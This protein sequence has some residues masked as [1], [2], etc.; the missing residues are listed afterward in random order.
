[1]AKF[2]LTTDD[3]ALRLRMEAWLRARTGWG[4]LRIESIEAIS[5]GL[6]NEI[7][8]VDV[9]PGDPGMG[10]R[11]R[12][13][14]RW[15]PL[16]GP[17]APY[18]MVGQFLLFEALGRTAVPVPKP[19][20][21]EADAS[22]IGRAFWLS[23]FVEGETM[24]RLLP[25][26]ASSARLAGFV[27]ALATIHAADWGF[28]GLADHCP[29]IRP[30]GIAG[31][32]EQAA[33]DFVHL[34]D[35]DRPLFEVVRQS[36]HSSAPTHF[37][38]A[39]THGDCSLSNYLFRG[40]RVAAVVDWDLRRITD[41]ILDLG[42]YCA[43]SDRFQMTLLPADRAARRMRV[44]EAY[45]ARTGRSLQTLPFW[46]MFCTFFNALTWVRPGWGARGDGFAAYRVRLKELLDGGGTALA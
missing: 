26:N 31:L 27:D 38:P 16:E 21:V 32:V 14:L 24:G 45:R 6:V 9:D 17:Y 19:L 11:A 8:R 30:E 15:D 20:W 40:D 1:M 35:M 39:L 46:E 36:L 41:P 37:E 7:R 5:G 33:Q 4:G 13:V 10:G 18:D 43:I 23:E 22:V 28:V 25:P 12:Y 29:V 2:D 44:V 3:T 34:T 42:Y